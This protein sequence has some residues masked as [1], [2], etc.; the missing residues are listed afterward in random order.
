MKRS[1]SLALWTARTFAYHAAYNGLAR[2]A[3]RASSLLQRL[4]R[5]SGRGRGR[6]GRAAARYFES[7]MGDYEIIAEESGLSRDVFRGKHVLELGPGDT[8]ATAL[9]ARMRGATRWEGFDPFDIQSRRVSY[10]KKIYDALLEGAEDR[11]SQERLLDGCVVHGSPESLRAGGRRFDVVISRAAL[12]HVRDLPR[13]FAHVAAV[14][15]EDAVWIHKV[16]LRCHGITHRHP[17]DFLR[18]SDR[19]WHAMSS[20][21]DL[22]NRERAS[23]YLSLSR[24]VGW[25]AAW[26]ATTHVLDAAQ[27]TTARPFLA[28]RFRDMSGAELCILGLWLVQSRSGRHPLDVDALVAA[29]HHTLSHY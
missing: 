11:Q 21:I 1:P 24:E 7:V 28:R 18:F 2:T 27:V 19:T 8:R 3:P 26:A 29:P 17:L 4:S 5:D 12:E 23:M 20:H 9:L 13:L 22:P 14:A 16:D 15:R 10:L 25:P 6:D